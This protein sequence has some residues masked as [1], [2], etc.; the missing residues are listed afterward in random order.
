LSQEVAILDWI[1][2]KTAQLDR[3]EQISGQIKPY[4]H[5][6]M[7]RLRRFYDNDVPFLPGER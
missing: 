7:D 1:E 6:V 3:I 4:L 5:E 2:A